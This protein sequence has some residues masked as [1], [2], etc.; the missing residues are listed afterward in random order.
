MLFRYACFISY[1]HGAQPATQRFYETFRNELAAQVDY[2]LPGMDVYLDTERIRGGD[3]FN[4]ALARALCGSACMVMLFNPRYF[5]TSN[6]YAA[7]EYQAMVALETQRLSLLPAAQDKGLIIP[8]IIRGT[9]PDTVRGNRQAYSMDYVGAEDLRT[10]RARAALRRVAEDIF[11][12]HEAFRSAA[13]DP[14]A[15]CD[16]FEFPSEDDISDWLAGVTA[17]APRMPWR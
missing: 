4:R 8:I 17:P 5:D 9:L 12:R 13:G 6:P 15:M 11:E 14:F 7:R 2:W 3:F 10:R 16:D 1:R